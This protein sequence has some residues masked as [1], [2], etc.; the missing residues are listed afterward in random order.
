V[1]S[2]VTGYLGVPVFLDLVLAAPGAVQ[3]PHGAAAWGLMLVTTAV[4]L[5]GIGLAHLAYVRSP[6]LPA[7][8]AQQWQRI[9][10][11]SFHK[12]YV[13][14]AYDRTVVRPTVRLADRLWTGVD[15]GLIDAAVN[16]IARA[17]AWGGWMMRLFQS[18]QA[19]HYALGMTIGAVVLL[20]MYLL[21]YT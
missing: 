20:G 12:W 9:Y 10:R 18:G 11:L 19:Q 7:R 2:I 4:G 21:F 17:I 5:A 15:M 13:D 6:D 16:G 8:L 14:E 1:L 3:E